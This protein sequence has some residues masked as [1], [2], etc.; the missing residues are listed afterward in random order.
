M[1][2][3]KTDYRGMTTNERLYVAGLLQQ[4]DDA[5]R[6]RDKRLMVCLL[7]RVDIAESDAGD[8]AESILADPTQYGL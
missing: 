8:I 7:Q 3:D 4:F 1:R 5:A 6:S 2:F